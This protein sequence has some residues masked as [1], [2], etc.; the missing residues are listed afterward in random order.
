MT[1]AEQIQQVTEAMKQTK[2]KRQYERYLAVRLRLEGRTYTEIAEV[3]GRTYQSISSYCKCYE[4]N[5]LSALDMG[6]SPGGPK[7]L[8]EQQEQ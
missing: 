4:E 2:N 1:T 8:T 3:L 6:H 5:G 7:K